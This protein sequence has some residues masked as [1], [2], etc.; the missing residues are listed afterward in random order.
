MNT[1]FTSKVLLTLYKQLPRAIRENENGVLRAAKCGFHTRG[2]DNTLR[3]MEKILSKN[4]EKIDMINLKLLI[5]KAFN[6]MLAEDI[7]IINMRFIKGLRFIEMASEL[8]ISLRQAFRVYDRAV[9]SFY[10]QLE[11][12]KYPAERIERDFGHLSI[13]QATCFR[14]SNEYGRLD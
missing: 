2:T 5:D 11:Y 4:N 14:L 7:R 1:M 3:L 13:Y 9:E 10:N 8:D 6:L 12:L